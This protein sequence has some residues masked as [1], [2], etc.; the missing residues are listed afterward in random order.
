MRL[1]LFFL[2]A[3][4]VGFAGTFAYRTY[5]KHQI[6]TPAPSTFSLENP[7]SNSLK[8]QITTFSGDAFLQSRTASLP[9]EL[10]SLQEVVQGE[11][12]VTKDK[13]TITVAFANRET[14]TIAPNSEIDFIQTLPANIVVAQQAGKIQYTK[15]STV[16]FSITAFSLL[17]NQQQGT[18]TVLVDNKNK[19]A[20]VEV[21]NG[22]VQL[23][24]VDTDQNTQVVN[25]S[26]GQTFVYDATTQT[27]DVSSH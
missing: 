20:T 21:K 23:A 17:V 5:T 16:P 13:G 14:L 24:Y 4:C 18:L 11:N 9:A 15:S 7:P 2:L 1:A 27:G 25:L 6:E 3:I 8:G 22:S 19:T 26:Q 10:T 12:L